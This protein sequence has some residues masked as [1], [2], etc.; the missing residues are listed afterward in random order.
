MEAHSTLKGDDIVRPA[1]KRAAVHKRTGEGVAA[2]VEQCV[3]A[4]DAKFANTLGYRSAADGASVKQTYFTR[5]P[6]VKALINSLEAQW[7]KN[8]WKGGGYIEVAGGTMVWCPSQHKLLNYLLMGSEAVVQNEAICWVNMQIRKR[9]MTGHQLT[10][11]HDEATFEFKRE[12]EQSGKELLS[13]MYGVASDRL[14]LDVKITGTAQSG[15]NWLDV[16]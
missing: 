13:Q 1:W 8:S 9:K 2:L 6:K 16:H 3:G 12:E 5:L 14:G 7:R 4:G 11:I 10:C 15:K